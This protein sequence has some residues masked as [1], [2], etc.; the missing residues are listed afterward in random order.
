MKRIRF[1]NLLA[2][3]F[4]IVVV[5]LVFPAMGLYAADATDTAATAAASPL[6]EALSGFLSGFLFPLIN[7]LV[8]GLIGWAVVS[9]GKKYKIDALVSSEAL[10]QNAAYKGIALAEEMAAKKLKATA[11]TITSNE[12]L[13][14]AIAQVL[15][16]APKLTQ[17]EAS[18]YVESTLAKIKGSGATGDKAV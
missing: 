12:K 3:L 14:I 17:E 16:A 18:A 1:Y 4:V 2:L 8:V 15:K 5:F 7:A 13:N 9:V 10:I 11:V 6:S